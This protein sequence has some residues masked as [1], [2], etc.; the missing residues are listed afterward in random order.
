MM[1]QPTSPLCKQHGFTLLE[2]LIALIIFSI[3]I[4]G[5]G[6][7]VSR[8]LNVQKDMHVDFIIINL[9]QNKL[10]N[11]LATTSAGDVCNGINL[12]HF[13]LAKT[14]YYMGCANE[15]IEIDSTF[16]TWPVLAVS[17]DQNTANACAEGSHD[18]RCYVVG[19]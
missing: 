16:V 2:S 15:K 13:V 19:R 17:T 14:T 12:D 9:M 18:D 5:S 3:I 6:T 8:M 10:Q 11:A 7:A 4:L 1:K